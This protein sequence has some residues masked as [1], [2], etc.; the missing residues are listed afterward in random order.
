MGPAGAEGALVSA[1]YHRRGSLSHRWGVGG[2]DGR[3]G[4]R[5]VTE[6]SHSQLASQ[7]CPVSKAGVGKAEEKEGG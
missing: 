1:I 2:A 4:E 7:S 5:L 3:G 6:T